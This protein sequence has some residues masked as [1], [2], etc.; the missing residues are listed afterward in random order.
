LPS[1]IQVYIAADLPTCLALHP[2]PGGTPGHEIVI[3]P[4]T[5]SRRDGTASEVRSWL[6]SFDIASHLLVPESLVASTFGRRRSSRSPVNT[7]TSTGDFRLPTR[8]ATAKEVWTVSDI[9]EIGGRGPY[10]LDLPIRYSS[11]RSRMMALGSQDR[12]AR[13]VSLL[14]ARPLANH[15][16]VHRFPAFTLLATTS[17]PI[18][19]ELFSLS[20]VDE[21]LPGN[22]QVLGP[23]E[24]EFVQRATELDLGARLPSDI[25]AMI[26]GIRHSAI[27]TTIGRVVARMGLQVD[28]VLHSDLE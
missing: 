19:A 27:D 23:W 6:R 10:V 7:E 3:L 11:L 22:A 15:L 5:L 17:D 24:D 26:H 18:V 9:N 21:D 28:Q 16:I 12:V 2:A 25:Q 13:S 20:L 8:L 14:S 4:S 1:T